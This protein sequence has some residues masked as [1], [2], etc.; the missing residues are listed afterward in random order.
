MR[1]A[2]WIPAAMLGL[3]RAGWSGKELLLV[4]RMFAVSC[5]RSEDNMLSLATL[6]PSPACIFLDKLL[7]ELTS[8][9]TVAS[10]AQS[11]ST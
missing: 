4:R 5:S 10:P 2:R 9:R 6:N 8:R 11:L 1:L 7:L 3:G